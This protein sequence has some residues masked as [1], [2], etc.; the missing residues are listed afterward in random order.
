[1]HPVDESRS[2]SAMSA[3]AKRYVITGVLWR[4]RGCFPLHTEL[5]QRVNKES[6]LILF[7]RLSSSLLYETS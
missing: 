5:S 7:K 1:M 3:T 2:L 6:I 4:C